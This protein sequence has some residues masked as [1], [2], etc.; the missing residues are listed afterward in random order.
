MDHFPGE[1]NPLN[2]S[3]CQ[4]R[5]TILN[6]SWDRNNTLDLSLI[7]ITNCQ[8]KTRGLPYYEKF[9]T[10]FKCKSFLKS[11]VKYWSD[12]KISNIFWKIL[13]S[14]LIKERY[15]QTKKKQ[16]H[17]MLLYEL[18]FTVC[19]QF[20]SISYHHQFRQ[21]SIATKLMLF[22]RQASNFLQNSTISNY[23][24]SACCP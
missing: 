2:P 1:N 22:F 21:H 15:Y 18:N 19:P 20:A 11:C 3:K 8:L 10:F 9:N 7:H 5:I 14:S 24:A 12:F 17:K 4:M 13:S 16:F 6:Q 23:C